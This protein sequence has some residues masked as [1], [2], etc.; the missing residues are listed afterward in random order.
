MPGLFEDYPTREETMRIL[1]FDPSDTLPVSIEDVLPVRDGVPPIDS[2]PDVPF[3]LVPSL[4]LLGRR[5]SEAHGTWIPPEDP[6]GIDD[7]DLM[8]LCVPPFAW[9]MGIKREKGAVWEGA[10]SIKGVWDVVLYDLRKFARLLCKQN[11]SVL[12]MLWLD[13]EDY[14]FV[15][16]EGRALINARG[17]FQSRVQAHDAF[18]GYAQGQIKG[19]VEG[20]FAG[21][22][23]EKRKQLVEKYGYDTKKAAHCVRLLHMGIE[24]LETG[25]LRVRRVSDVKML[26]NIKRGGWKLDQVKS[27]AEE[28][29]KSLHAALA[30]SV[31]RET[32]DEGAIED[33]VVHIMRDRGTRL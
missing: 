11:P 15:R 21:Y 17:L 28:C 13:P 27:H 22:M 26:I 20:T 6:N 5:G 25:V 8:G 29:L 10:D 18:A 16:P 9:S 2:M 24:Y 12:S 19:M 33:L 31:L 3:P 32:I 23:G 4:I 1:T 14:L 7:R 30:H